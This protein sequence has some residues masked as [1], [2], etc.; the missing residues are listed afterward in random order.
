MDQEER[1]RLTSELIEVINQLQILEMSA[2]LRAMARS[3]LVQREI[4]LKQLLGDIE[5]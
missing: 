4:E 1:D 2:G 5:T 3:P